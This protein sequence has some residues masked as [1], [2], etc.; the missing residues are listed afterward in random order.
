MK[1]EQM[2]FRMLTTHSRLPI[3]LD[4]HTGGHK[5]VA[6]RGTCTR[7]HGSV[8]TG[9]RCWTTIRGLW[10]WETTTLTGFGRLIL[11][12]WRMYRRRRRRD[13]RNCWGCHN[14]NWTTGTTTT[15]TSTQDGQT[16]SNWRGLL[17]RS[18]G[19]SSPWGSRICV[20]SDG[21]RSS[22]WR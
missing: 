7:S 9:L 15:S 12:M 22:R 20:H 1:T 6:R 16:G 8:L 2:K 11:T 4:N 18:H 10:L 13:Q 3:I 5:M 21:T 14:N 19:L 17:F